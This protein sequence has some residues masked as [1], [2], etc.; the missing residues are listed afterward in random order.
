[1]TWFQL[2]IWNLSM[3]PPLD[4]QYTLFLIHEYFKTFGGSSRD[5]Q[6]ATALKSLYEKLPLVPPLVAEYQILQPLYLHWSQK[7]ESVPKVP[8]CAVSY[9]KLA[10]CN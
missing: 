10:F 7:K 9:S 3:E 4:L 2:L 6:W 5:N 8:H 1:M